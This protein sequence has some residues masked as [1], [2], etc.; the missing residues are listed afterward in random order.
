MTLFDIRVTT[1][2]NRR[3]VGSSPT[4]GARKKALA[5]AS[6]FFNEINPFRD[7]WNALRAWN[8]PAACE[9]AAAVRNLKLVKKFGLIEEWKID[10]VLNNWFPNVIL[11]NCNIIQYTQ[12]FFLKLPRMWDDWYQSSHI[13]A[14]SKNSLWVDYRSVFPAFTCFSENRFVPQVL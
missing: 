10:L 13:R 8:T 1:T 6:A 11:L 9:I 5:F 12:Q 7:L 14:F 2:V 3:V 4:G